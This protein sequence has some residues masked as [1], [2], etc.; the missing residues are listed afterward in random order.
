[1]HNRRIYRTGAALDFG[2][3]GNLIRLLGLI[4]DLPLRF[5]SLLPFGQPVARKLAVLFVG[6]QR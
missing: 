5:A 4:C 3:L 2:L 1:L 6:S